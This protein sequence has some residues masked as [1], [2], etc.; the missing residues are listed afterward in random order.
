MILNKFRQWM[1]GRYGSDHLNVCLLVVYLILSMV[2]IPFQKYLIG[3]VISM[4]LSY[5]LIILIFYRMFSKNVTK[6]YQENQKFLRVWN[7]LK[8]RWSVESRHLKERKDYHFYKC[9]QCGQKIRIPRGKGK[10]CITCP[11]CK[12]EF[13]KNS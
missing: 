3:S 10:I 5:A 13:I 11:K 7:R 2:S 6:R 4:I 8:G 1:A 9:D 12:H